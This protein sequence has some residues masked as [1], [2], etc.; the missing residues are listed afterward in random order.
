L[1]RAISQLPGSLKRDANAFSPL[2][3]L[4][5]TVKEAGIQH[6]VLVPDEDLAL[7]PWEVMSED[8]K[9]RVLEQ[10]D[11]SYVPTASLLFRPARRVPW[12]ARLPWDIQ[13]QGFGEPTAAAMTPE[14]Q[15]PYSGT[16]VR[17]I[18]AMCYGRSDLHLGSQ[19]TKAAL[20][21]AVALPIPIVHL[22]TH[23]S[24]DPQTP[25]GSHL[26]FS[27]EEGDRP[28][29]LYLRELY[30]LDLRNVDL[31]TL[32]ACETERGHL[33]R[34]EG[35]QA[36]SRAL[37]SAGSSSTLTTLWKVDDEATAEFMKQFYFY[38]IRQA[39]PKAEA[40]RLAKLKFAHS[41][42]AYADPE[43]WAAFV[44]NGDGASRTPRFLSWSVLLALSVS[45]LVLLVGFLVW[46]CRRRPKLNRVAAIAASF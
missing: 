9:N 11:V 32:S 40:L 5:L 35:V 15:L 10:A 26:V 36:F 13:F 39:R 28:D 37:L 7:I 21:R 14:Q 17:S 24:A 12:R 4:L 44:L 3:S 33:V 38:A 41:N 6:I 22:S 23:A 29:L 46:R 34:G 25:E 18:A 1:H 45:A 27:S 16:E 31:I 42:S 19:D 43:V 20:M 2:S 8:G 30:A